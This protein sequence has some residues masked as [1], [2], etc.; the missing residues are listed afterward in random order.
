[1]REWEERAFAEAET[2]IEAAQ[3]QWAK[4][5]GNVPESVLHK[6]MG[7]GVGGGRGRKSLFQDYHRLLHFTRTCLGKGLSW[8]EIWLEGDIF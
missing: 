6:V 5:A 4:T 3:R 2:M 7:G 1:M 8:E